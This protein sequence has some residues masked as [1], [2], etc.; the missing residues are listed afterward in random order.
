MA[1][2]Q[3]SVSTPEDHVK[4]NAIRTAVHADFVSRSVGSARLRK[5]SVDHP[6]PAL[7]LAYEYHGDPIR[8]NEIVVRNNISNPAFALGQL[9][10][11]SI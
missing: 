8:A 4:I 1:I 6:T 2:Q 5:V 3:S 7:V 9:S 10:I 11:L